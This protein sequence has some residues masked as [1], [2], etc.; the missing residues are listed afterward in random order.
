[1]ALSLVGVLFLLLAI[2][3]GGGVLALTGVPVAG[4]YSTLI[5]V[6]C[7]AVGLKNMVSGVTS[8]NKAH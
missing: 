4:L 2:A 3:A 5:P 7:F 6:A 8:T 1:M